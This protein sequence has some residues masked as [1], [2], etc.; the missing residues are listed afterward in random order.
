MVNL[1]RRSVCAAGLS[2]LLLTTFANKLS[3]QTS[4]GGPSVVTLASTKSANRLDPH[5]DVKWEVLMVLSA[6]YDTLVYQDAEGNIVPGLASAWTVSDDG[7]TY[8]FTL[9]DG[10]TFHDGAAFDA[11]AVKFNFDRIQGLGPKS[12]KASSLIADVASV[13]VVSP[14]EVKLVMAQANSSL[15]SNLS[16]TFCAMVSPAAAQQ[17][18]DEYHMHQVGTGPY[19][20]AEYEIGDHYKLVKNE[21]YAWAPGIYGH[22]GPALVDELIWRFL[23]E[24][25]SRSAALLAGDFDIVFDLLPTSLRRVE[26]S[27]DYSVT[28]SHLSGQPAYWFMNTQLAPTDDPAVRKALIMGVDIEAGVT[29]IMRGVAPKASGPL[30]AVTPEYAPEVAGMYSLDKKGAAALLDEAGWAVGSDGIRAKDGQRLV[31]KVQMAGWGNSESFSVLLQ[32]ELK[33]LGVE[34]EL[35][36]MAY[37]VGIE[38]GRNGT[39]NMLFT[40]GSGFSVS[41]SLLP[42]FLSENV[43]S[44]F[45]FAKYSDPELDKLLLGAQAASDPAERL[46]LYQQA[47]VMIMEKALILPIYDYALA[48]GVSNEIEG[49]N[50][51]ATGL[52]P[53]VYELEL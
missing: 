19:K 39:H 33:E 42:Y 10:V 53:N 45:A 15:L 9:R 35:E 20:M 22:E 25:S 21:D 52:V 5:V 12:Y 40:G 30:S 23:P 43:E 44:G 38:A 50:F 24:P 4:A 11:E 16:L 2:S 37:M 46:S 18:G 8:S 48:I 7:M 27:S 29:A 14:T 13:E 3:A 34:V 6:M 26:A 47:Q 41:D 49:L 51:G 28:A 36:M 17:W 32:S 31:L 1:T